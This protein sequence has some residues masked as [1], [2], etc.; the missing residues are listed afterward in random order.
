MHEQGGVYQNCL[1]RSSDNVYWYLITN[2]DVQGRVIKIDHQD[3]VSCAWVQ[4]S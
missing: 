4:L 2:N 1:G 3:R